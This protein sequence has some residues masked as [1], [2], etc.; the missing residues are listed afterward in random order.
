[1]KRRMVHIFL[2]FLLSA[3]SFLYF[4]SFLLF[5]FLFFL[6]AF[7][8]SFLYSFSFSFFFQLSF[9]FPFS[10]SFSFFNLFLKVYYA[11]A[12]LDMFKSIAPTGPGK[13]VILKHAGTLF[14]LLSFLVF[15]PFLLFPWRR[16]W[17]CILC[18]FLFS[19]LLWFLFLSTFLTF[20][21]GFLYRIEEDNPTYFFHHL[22]LIFSIP[23]F[24]IFFLR[25]S[26]FFFVIDF[27]KG[28]L[29]RVE[30]EN[31]YLFLPSSAS[32]KSYW[33]FDLGR[34]SIKNELIPLS[35]LPG[36]KNKRKEEIKKRKKQRKRVVPFSSFLVF[37]P[38]LIR[39]E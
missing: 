21:K 36:E 15:S 24:F 18:F 33:K 6:L 35:Q 11:Q 13:K 28:F 22:L 16:L 31:P 1:M 27:S 39:K 14:L 8:P 37:A 4:L 3:F 38:F 25:S 2:F 32:G 34:I 12:M 9:F 20:S 23:C 10:F 17:S 7:S 19:F 26:S 30:V 29:Y 5:L